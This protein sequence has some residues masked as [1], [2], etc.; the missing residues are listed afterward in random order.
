MKLTEIKNRTGVWY[1]ISTRI[2]ATITSQF[3]NIH[4]PK[5]TCQVESIVVTNVWSQVYF[6][7]QDQIH[8]TLNQISKQ[9][10]IV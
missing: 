5:I 7:I 4:P 8:E 6:K 10:P 3:Y 9:L 2:R 1:H